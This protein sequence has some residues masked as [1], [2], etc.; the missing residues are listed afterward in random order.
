M[1]PPFRIFAV[2]ETALAKRDPS[3]IPASNFTEPTYVFFTDPYP[4]AALKVT[5]RLQRATTWPLK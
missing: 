2:N 4:I 1:T 3:Y 5:R